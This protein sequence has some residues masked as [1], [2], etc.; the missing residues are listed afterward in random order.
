MS[1]ENI[2]QLRSESIALPQTNVPSFHVLKLP[3]VSA[4][5][6][7]LRRVFVEWAIQP[8]STTHGS[9][10]WWTAYVLLAR[11]GVLTRGTG[12]YSEWSE[13][14]NLSSQSAISIVNPRRDGVHIAEIAKGVLNGPQTNHAFVQNV[15][16]HGTTTNLEV[17]A[18]LVASGMHDGGYQVHGQAR[19][20]YRVRDRE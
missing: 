7:A 16:M 17:F 3:A 13:F 2:D 1:D 5:V 14:A 8:L 11:R 9:A 20:E 6:T 12:V 10:I 15:N 18:C 19:L 4:D